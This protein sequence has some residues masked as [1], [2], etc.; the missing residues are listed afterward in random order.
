[1]KKLFFSTIIALVVLISMS[2]C[3]KTNYCAACE[4][5]NTGYQPAD[6]CGSESDVDDYISELKTQGA[7]VGQ[8]W[9]CQKKEE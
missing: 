8:S 1:M 3:T 7:A 9:S 4:E 5:A 6:F 2:S